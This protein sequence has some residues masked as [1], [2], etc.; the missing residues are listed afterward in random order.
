MI[1]GFKVKPL[2]TASCHVRLYIIVSS[3]VAMGKTQ[4]A[5]AHTPLSA[6]YSSWPSWTKPHPLLSPDA[7]FFMFGLI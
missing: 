1:N 5:T 3:W 6:T 4:C 2:A 7:S